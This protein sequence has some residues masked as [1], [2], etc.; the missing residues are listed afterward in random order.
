M[1]KIGLVIKVPRGK[2]REMVQRQRYEKGGRKVP[3]RNL[4]KCDIMKSAKAYKSDRTKLDLG[5]LFL[6]S[7]VTHD[8]NSEVESSRNIMN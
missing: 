6:F 7:Y 3:R 1:N 4:N 8:C 2:F 5:S